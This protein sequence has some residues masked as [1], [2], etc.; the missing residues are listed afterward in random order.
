MKYLLLN[1]GRSTIVDD[2]DYKW[3]SQW[4][5]FC[6]TKGYAVRWLPRH[7][8]LLYMHRIIMNTPDD[9]QVDHINRN[10]LDNRK[11]NLRNV[12]NIVNERNKSIYKNN[13]SGYKGVSWYKASQKWVVH[14]SIDC[15]KKTI[16]YF[17]NF[18]EAVAE[19][20][21]LEKIYYVTN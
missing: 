19:R 21:R 11:E 10:R 9:K 17:D 14:I 1:R 2:E 7:E 3:L 15:R 8:K 4:R 5:W 13:K 18:E 16:G 12:E 6:S 20:K